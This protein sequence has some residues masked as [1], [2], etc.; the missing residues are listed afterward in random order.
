V[1]IGQS[2]EMPQGWRMGQHRAWRRRLFV[3]D[4]LITLIFS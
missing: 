3:G 2:D 4:Y 1:H